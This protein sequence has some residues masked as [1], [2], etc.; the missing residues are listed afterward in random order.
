MSDSPGQ[1]INGFIVSVSVDLAKQGNTTFA[2]QALRPY[3]YCMH[4]RNQTIFRGLCGN[5]TPR[6]FLVELFLA[7]KENEGREILSQAMN[8]PA[9]L[10]QKAAMTWVLWTQE[11]ERRKGENTNEW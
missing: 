1:S 8:P 4:N 9:L 10:A 7:P 6:A 2:P 5:W 3:L 11:D